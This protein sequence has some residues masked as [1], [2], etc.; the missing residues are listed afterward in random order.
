M[1]GQKTC[2]YKKKRFKILPEIDQIYGDGRGFQNLACLRT[3]ERACEELPGIIGEIEWKDRCKSVSHLR[4]GANDEPGR[5]ACKED[6]GP[7][8]FSRDVE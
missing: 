8:V 7:G 2:F 1:R 3:R 6:R 4:K 5:D